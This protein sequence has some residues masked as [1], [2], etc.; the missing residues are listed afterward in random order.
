[1][2]AAET[3]DGQSSLLRRGP[4]AAAWG[5][6]AG[7]EAKCREMQE[8]EDTCLVCKDGGNLVCCEYGH[9]DKVCAATAAPGDGAAAAL[10][11]PAA[12]CSISRSPF[13]L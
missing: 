6:G 7:A 9:T 5:G 13:P 3:S 11:L 8:W 4:S 2:G 1:M 12:A 10:L